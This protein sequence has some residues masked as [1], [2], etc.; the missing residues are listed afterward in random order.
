M[1]ILLYKFILGGLAGSIIGF[2]SLVH[3]ML[4]K[5]G[6]VAAGLLGALICGYGPWSTWLVLLLFFGSSGGI[7]LLTRK[8]SNPSA[9]SI[10]EK[11]HTR[12]A[13]QVTANSLPALFCLMLFY[14]TQQK[15]FLIGYV[16]G[17]AGATADTWASEIGTLSKRPP[18][19]ILTLKKVPPGISGGISPLGLGATLA[20]SLLIAGVFW[21]VTA[22]FSFAS[23]QILLIPLLCGCI[24]SVIDSLLGAAFQVKY[25]C[26]I[27][28]ALTEKRV[29]H[30]EPAIHIAGISWL[31]NDWV[32]F[33]SGVITIVISFIIGL[34]IL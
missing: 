27:C 9:T 22:A 5:S 11:G 33:F 3:R 34:L 13:F 17:I 20:G 2:F 28:G 15:L 23:Y 7:H 12:D 18:R 31:T 30:Q 8:L 6:A 25:R 26:K 10:T 24:N 32:N 29:H 14:Y 1:T 16:S 21:L 4:T 19:S